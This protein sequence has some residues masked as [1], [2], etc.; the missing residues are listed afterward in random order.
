MLSD[1]LDYMQRIHAFFVSEHHNSGV[2]VVII[3]YFTRTRSCKSWNYFYYILA[4]ICYAIAPKLLQI[5]VFLQ[6]GMQ[7]R[8]YPGSSKARLKL[9]CATST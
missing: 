1:L 8:M 3:T 7:Q 4:G 2:I 9:W 6:I 5:G